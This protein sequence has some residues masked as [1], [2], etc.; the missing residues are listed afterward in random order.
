[1]HVALRQTI[2]PVAGAPVVWI[3]VSMRVHTLRRSPLSS[4]PI[5]GILVLFSNSLRVAVMPIGRKDI[6][7]PFKYVLSI[8]SRSAY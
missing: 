3:S 4:L 6:H 7:P 1:M 2:K 5:R 8:R